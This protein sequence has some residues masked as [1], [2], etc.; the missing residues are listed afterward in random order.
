[1]NIVVE[2]SMVKRY[3]RLA[4]MSSEDDARKITEDFFNKLLKFMQGL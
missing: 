4:G 3:N 1:M 2:L